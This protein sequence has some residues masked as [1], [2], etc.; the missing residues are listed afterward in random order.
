M[1]S[2][3]RWYVVD[4]W[5]GGGPFDLIAP[6][7]EPLEPDIDTVYRERET[8]IGRIGSTSIFADGSMHSVL[9]GGYGPGGFPYGYSVKPDH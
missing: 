7:L 5:W 3:W 9:Y 8:G 2:K 1:E 6:M 4:T